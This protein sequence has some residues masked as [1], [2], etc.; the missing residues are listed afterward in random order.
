MQS[1]VGSKLTK[2]VLW[3][4][5]LLGMKLSCLF[6]TYCVNKMKLQMRGM[7]VLVMI[8]EVMR[9]LAGS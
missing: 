5:I 2:R 3:K 8:Y 7:Q 9:H 6:P 4:D 1:I